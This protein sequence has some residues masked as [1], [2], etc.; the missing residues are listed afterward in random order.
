LNGL[1]LHLI[2]ETAF[3]KPVRLTM[4]SLR[5]GEVPVMRATRD[6]ILEPR[7][8]SMLTATELWG[9]FFDTTFAYRF[10]EAS[11]DV[12]FAQICDGESGKLIAEAFH[13]PLGRG[14][15]Q[16]DLNLRAE[17]QQ[18]DTQWFLNLTTQRLAQSVHITDEIY[19][20]EDNWFHLAP[21]HTRRIALSPRSP[22]DAAPS[23]RIAAVNG[24]CI[25]YGCIL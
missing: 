9:G 13:F 14:H 22:T 15:A 24:D 7:S 20:P 4:H 25:T 5:D 1:A 2:N 23:G 21:G 10:G 12:T 18:E 3:Q 16:Q 11:H 8:T 6:L 19:T 17:I